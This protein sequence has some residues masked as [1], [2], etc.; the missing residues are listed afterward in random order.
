MGDSRIKRA[1]PDVM[2]RFTQKFSEAMDKVIRTVNSRLGN[3]ID[4]GVLPA[5]ANSAMTG[6]N[7]WSAIA[8]ISTFC[9]IP[10]IREIASLYL[11]KWLNNPALTEPVKALVQRLSDCLENETLTHGPTSLDRSLI[12]SDM[13]VVQEIVKL[14]SKLKASQ[15]EVYNGI[16]A[17]V[18]QRGTAVCVLVFRLLIIEDLIASALKPE[19][20]KLL[21]SLIIS[22]SKTID[23]TSLNNSGY[24]FS[25]SIQ[26]LGL[27]LSEII[28]QLENKFQSSHNKMLIDLLLRILRGLEL[29]KV[30]SP[31]FLEALL[32]NAKAAARSSYNDSTGTF[33]AHLLHSE[34]FRFFADVAVVFQLLNANEIVAIRKIGATLGT[35]AGTSTVS[36]GMSSSVS[37]NT[38]VAH[39]AGMAGGRGMAAGRLGGMGRAGS[40]GA[41]KGRL[42]TARVG[43]LG[44]IHRMPSGAVAPVLHAAPLSQ[45]FK[46]AAEGGNGNCAVEGRGSS[47]G[48]IPQAALGIGRVGT[49]RTYMTTTLHIQETMATW[50]YDIL[51]E[52]N[53]GRR[54]LSSSLQDRQE[55]VLLTDAVDWLQRVT[56]LH[57]S[58]AARFGAIELDKLAHFYLRDHAPLSSKLLSALVSIIRCLS[59][60]QIHTSL[61]P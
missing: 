42:G 14:R 57:P 40:A 15:V 5:A 30:D 11:E 46:E 56:G 32:G 34:V 53:V 22:V 3:V 36:G 47:A 19:T 7:S 26:L 59:K 8:T 17:A 39:S 31:A 10:R 50:L 45:V 41:V 58:A 44:A 38:S 55:A 9:K 43:A 33:Q 6:A 20:V 51:M 49:E 27:A 37:A 25:K 61:P 24:S 2:N 48:S 1:L 13:G 16:L 23:K 29:R 28:S 12:V 18:I 60:F 52:L 21:I 4:L 35:G 54:T